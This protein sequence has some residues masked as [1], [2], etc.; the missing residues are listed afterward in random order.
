MKITQL[1]S[2]ASVVWSNGLI[3]RAK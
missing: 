2:Y 1:F 3:L